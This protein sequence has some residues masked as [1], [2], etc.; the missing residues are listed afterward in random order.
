[1]HGLAHTTASSLPIRDLSHHGMI[2]AQRLSI[3]EA[4]VAVGLEEGD[5]ALLPL[6][7]C[8][9]RMAARLDVSEVF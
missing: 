6:M 1:M 8:L 3:R 2:E 4:D 7:L 5:A 9:A